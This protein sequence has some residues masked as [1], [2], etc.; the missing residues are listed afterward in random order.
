ML[1]QKKKDKDAFITQELSNIPDILEQ[2]FATHGHNLNVN[3]KPIYD[4][5]K[6]DFTG[7]SMD[8][9]SIFMYKISVIKLLQQILKYLQKLLKTF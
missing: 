2:M 7:N 6:H 4:K 3:D 8:Y 5:Q 9:L 1:Q